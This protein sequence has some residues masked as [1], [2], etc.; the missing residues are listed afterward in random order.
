MGA[1]RPKADKSGRTS[2]GVLLWRRR[3]GRVE[4]LLGH[5]GGPYFAR[6][7]VGHWTVLKG[8]VEPGEDVMSVARR[9]FAEETGHDLPDGPMVELGQ[10]RQRS[11]KVVLAWAVEGNL[12]PDTAVS[13]TF[14]IEW[15]PR[16]GRLQAFPEIDRVAWFG[17]SEAR[18]TIKAAQTPF[19]DR[20]EASLETA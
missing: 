12:D 20:L 16:S 7:D 18:E 17:L 10:I 13:N 9:E 8:E 2:A 1:K 6:K 11:G 4:V 15:P 19:L 5:N 3:D 14:E